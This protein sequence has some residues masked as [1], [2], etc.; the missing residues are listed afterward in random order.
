MEGSQQIRGASKVYDVSFF[1]LDEKTLILTIRVARWKLLCDMLVRQDRVSVWAQGRSKVCPSSP[2][3]ASGQR[4]GERNGFFTQC[5]TSC[6]LI[7]GGHVLS[8]QPVRCLLI[9]RRQLPA[10][11]QA[12]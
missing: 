6:F 3:P 2:I 10:L 12:R 4:R 9:A 5:L 1:S 8:R 11:H 7:A